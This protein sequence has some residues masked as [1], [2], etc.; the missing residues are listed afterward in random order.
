VALDYETGTANDP[1]DL[2]DK[3]ETFAVANGW[4]VSPA[5]VGRVFRKDTVVVGVNTDANELFFRGAITYNAAAAFDAQTNNSGMTLVMLIGVGPYTAYHFFSGDETSAEYLHVSLEMTAGHY[6]NFSFGE[7]VKHGAYT[8]G[9]YVD[10]VVWDVSTSSRDLPDFGLHQAICDSKCVNEFD[11]HVWCDYD[12]KTNNWQMV[13]SASTDVGNPNRATGSYRSAGLHSPFQYRGYQL[14]N[15]Q[16]HLAPL[17]YF[18]N[19]ASSQRSPIGRIPNLRAISL[20]NLTPGE[21]IS[22]GGDDWIVFP[23]V[24]RSDIF[25]QG[26]LSVDE[27]SGYY[28]YAFRIP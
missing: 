4:T 13:T 5:T 21:I 28:G 7:L 10:G 17:T 16:N 20:N 1:E 9:V 11:A 23:L 25:N 8:G 15:L 27:S 26:S 3:L 18:V 6:R 19:R 24:R 22:I 14:W 12:A 2:I